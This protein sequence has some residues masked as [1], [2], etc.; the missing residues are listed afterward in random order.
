MSMFHEEKPP[1]SVGVC[2]KETERND[3][4]RRCQAA[5]PGAP[6]FGLVT[7]TQQRAQKES[8]AC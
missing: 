2:M 6:E 8:Q 4:E 7:L 1:D 3:R 5:D